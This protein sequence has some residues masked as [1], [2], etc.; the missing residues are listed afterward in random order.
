MP[1]SNHDEKMAAQLQTIPNG[2]IQAKVGNALVTIRNNAS[3]CYTTTFSDTPKAHSK[4][5]V[6]AVMAAVS[7]VI[8]Q[9][10]V[11]RLAS[12]RRVNNQAPAWNLAGRNEYHSTRF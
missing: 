12:I 4:E 6:A 2:T 3:N 7:I 9:E 8:G 5:L 1:L 10:K 11:F